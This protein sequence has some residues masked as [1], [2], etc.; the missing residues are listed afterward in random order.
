LETTHILTNVLLGYLPIVI[1][2]LCMP[3][4]SRKEYFFGVEVSQRQTESRDF[5]ELRRFYYKL[6]GTASGVLT[7]AINGA[8]YFLNNKNI[9]SFGTLSLL[10]AL[11]IIYAYINRRAALLKKGE[12]D[13]KVKSRYAYVYPM[14]FITIFTSVLTAVR[15]RGGSLL[16][17]SLIPASQILTTIAMLYIYRYIARKRWAM[18]IAIVGTGMAVCYMYFQLRNLGILNMG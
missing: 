2:G 16:E 14:V 11:I 10:G 4:F 7:L 6:Y 12:D 9:S 13:K 5:R 8:S 15:Y 17:T 18:T 1:V 3:K